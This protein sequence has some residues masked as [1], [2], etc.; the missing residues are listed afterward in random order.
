MPA[1]RKFKKKNPYEVIANSILAML[2]K[3]IVPWRQSWVNGHPVS[4]A[5]GKTYR[6]INSILLSVTAEIE[7]WSDPRWLTYNKA[8]QLGG[9]V[10]KGQKSTPICKYNVVEKDDPDN[11]DK[12]KVNRFFAYDCVF[13]VEQCEGLDLPTLDS[14]IAEFSPIEGAEQIAAG[15][16]DGPA[17]SNGGLACYRPL[18]DEVV[19][20]NRES[21][22]TEEAYY[23]ALFHELGHSTGHSKRLKRFNISEGPAMFGSES[24]GEEELVAEFCAS[25]LCGECEILPK[26]VENAVAY[27][28]GWARIIKAK[29]Q[30]I[31]Q[32]SGKAG[33][34]AD[35]I[36]GVDR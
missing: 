28:Q 4:V 16:K 1:K 10:K 18:T 2:N 21:F 20:P 23:A 35:R 7:G 13:N 6:G 26:T 27:I 25:F 8:K 31:V 17:V 5:T 9:N 12:K 36:L 30:I 33:R 15:Y 34:A 11:P 3:G 29:P 19:M 14:P 32:A 24:Y 22:E